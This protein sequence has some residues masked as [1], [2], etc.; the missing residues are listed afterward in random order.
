[1]GGLAAL[2]FGVRG[3][4][5]AV[6]AA[7]VRRF[8]WVAGITIG[9][10]AAAGVIR[11]ID[12]VQTWNA[13]IA[14][15][16]GHFVLFKSALL[17]ILA[18]LGAWNRFWNI[19]QAMRS[20]SGL[21]RVG[22]A[23]LAVGGVVFVLAGVLTGLAPPSL[24][25]QAPPVS[26]PIVVSGADFATS[27]R[28]RLEIAPGFPGPNRFVARI[29][30]YDTG[31]PIAADRVTLRFS[32]PDR[33]DIGQSSLALGRTADGIYEAEGTNLSLRGRWT[34]AAVIE[35]GSNSVEVT[36]GVATQARPLVVRTIE[37]P[38]QPTLY[39]IELPAG[40]VLDV[41]LD[42]G[43]AG[44]NEVHAT[45]IDASGQELSIPRPITITAVRPGV[46]A[47]ALPV[48]RF[49]PGHF[50]GDAPLGPGEWHLEFVGTDA[51][52]TILEATLTVR[53]R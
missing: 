24:F 37:A 6:K 39:G 21:R 32:K 22:G 20:L 11:A 42:P 46:A 30:D 23:E 53:L 1:L 49:G 5:D 43:R 29:A 45:Y 28:V 38:G 25:E 41:Y 52:G 31:R 33:P 40:R 51:G 36:I 2:L 4:P 3:A 12:E 19:P 48:R 18:A 47:R 50:V 35:R 34:V 44:F 13:L 10:V 16:F 9:I 17:L 15:K 14:T 26:Q 7:A 27:V 8:S